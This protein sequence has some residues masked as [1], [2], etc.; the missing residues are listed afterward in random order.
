[1]R[2]EIKMVQKRHI[3]EKEICQKDIEERNGERKNNEN[4][5]R[6]KNMLLVPLAVV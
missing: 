4:G 1:M 3:R 6:G 2:K 5:T